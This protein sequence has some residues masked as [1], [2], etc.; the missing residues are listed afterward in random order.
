MH[1]DY[2]RFIILGDARSGSTL[3]QQALNSHPNIVCFREIFAFKPGYIDYDVD[4]WDG[5]SAADYEL[6]QRDARAFLRERIFCAHADPIKAVGFKFHYV[7]FWFSEDTL[8][9]LTEDRELRVVHLQRRNMLRSLVSLRIAEQTGQWLQHDAVKHRMG[10]LRRKI[11]ISSIGEAM[12]QPG[13]SVTRIRNFLRP[14]NPPAQ[15]ERQ[16][17]VLTKDDC[18][19]H[20]YRVKHNE[21]HF[22]RE[23]EAHPSMVITF[24]ELA[25]NR[26]AVLG[27]V[28]DFLGVER[29]RSSATLRRQNPEPLRELVANYHELRAAYAGTEYEWFFD[30]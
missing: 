24:E 12:R 28:H 6:R 15:G 4:G 17:L 1:T 3:A 23:F 22:G 14:V 2:T 21:E 16:P 10:T 11:T 13:R 20:F 9:A 25:V 18:D 7:H 29:A 30:E 19:A 5:H 8:P 26:D 27:T